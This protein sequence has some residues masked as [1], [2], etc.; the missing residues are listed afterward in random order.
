R[1]LTCFLGVRTFVA[2][3][4]NRTHRVEVLPPRDHLR[5]AESRR[6][7]QFG[8]YLN[9]LRALLL[10][11]NVVSRKIGFRVGRPNQINERLLAGTGEDR[12]QPGG[13]RRR[14]DVMC[15]DCDWRRV[16]SFDLLLR[17]ARLVN[18]SHDRGAILVCFLP[19]KVAVDQ[20]WQGITA[21]GKFAS[22]RIFVVPL[23]TPVYT[24][25]KSD[26]SSLRR[27]GNRLPREPHAVG[28]KFCMKVARW[29]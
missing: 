22:D 11:I 9:W 7:Y 14:E 6:L 21:N 5:V 1:R 12:L 18:E 27:Q 10:A 26:P 29:N 28:R 15:D 16:V 4:I 20:C 8:I 19:F 25:R 23:F 2:T 17:G 3:R 13:G 24:I